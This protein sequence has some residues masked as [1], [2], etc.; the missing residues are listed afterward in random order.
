MCDHRLFSA[1]TFGT[2]PPQG[3]T[4][5]KIYIILSIPLDD[6]AVLTPVSEAVQ[7]TDPEDLVSG[8]VEALDP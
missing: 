6:K 7:E 8:F 1:S 5:R 3:P 4:H 2:I